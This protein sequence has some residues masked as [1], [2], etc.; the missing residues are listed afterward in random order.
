MI[1]GEKDALLWTSGY[2]PWID[3]YLGPETPNPLFI[4]ILRSSGDLPNIK[5]VLHDIMRLT[6]INYSSPTSTPKCNTGHSRGGG[7]ARA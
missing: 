3:T 1:L 2:V 7:V 4:T 6:K 5:D